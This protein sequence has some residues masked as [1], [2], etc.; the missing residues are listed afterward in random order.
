MWKFLY[1]FLPTFISLDDRI[2]LWLWHWYHSSALISYGSVWSQMWSHFKCV[3]LFQFRNIGSKFLIFWL[4]EGFSWQYLHSLQKYQTPNLN[5]CSWWGPP[6]VKIIAVSN[7]VLTW[8]TP[9]WKGIHVDLGLGEA[10]D[11]VRQQYISNIWN[12]KEISKQILSPQKCQILGLPQID[13]FSK[14]TISHQAQ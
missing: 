14:T 2:A 4:C 9:H 12:W 3:N 11:G 13:I 10:V 8:N 6:L 5:R 7:L 1:Y